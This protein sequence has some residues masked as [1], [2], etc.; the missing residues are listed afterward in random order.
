MSEDI[1][2][3]VF[4]RIHLGLISMHKEGPRKNGGIGFSVVGPSARVS[5][6]PAVELTVEDSRHI[7]FDAREMQEFV[8][9]LKRLRADDRL[10]IV[11]RFLI[12]G[13]MYTHVGMGSGTA[14]KLAAVEGLYRLN[15]KRLSKPDLVGRSGRGG[16]SGIGVSTYFTGKM[17]LDLGVANDGAPI[18]PSSQY[19][20]GREPVIVAESPMP[21]W[22]LC[23]CVPNSIRP[24][25][26]A[27][28]V[29]FFERTTPL[30]PSSSYRASYEALFGVYA[31]VRESHYSA[32]C[33]SIGLMQSMDWKAREWAEYGN[34]LLELREK[35]LDCG[36]DCVGM[37]SLGP[38]LFCFGGRAS[39]DRV[40]ASQALLDISAFRTLPKNSGR[41]INCTP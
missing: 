37:S 28:E 17:I 29:E 20:V 11:G 3:D 22:E 32:F 36:V 10:G 27:E 12:Q 26:Q 13:D 41:E 8:Q 2:I 9:L 40:M 30:D 19:R 23:L 16:T 38:M 25:T 7:A 18:V 24:K 14:L 21:A 33:R 1:T 6:T 5:I 34:P 35:L 15:G 39:L 4:P 31:A